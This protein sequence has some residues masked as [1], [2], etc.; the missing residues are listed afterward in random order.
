MSSV[1]EDINIALEGVI[2][3]V[4]GADYNPLLFKWSVEKNDFRNN[5]KMYGSMPLGGS[6]ETGV[7]KSYTIAQTYEFVLTHNY[8][9]RDG[10]EDKQ[11]KTF[12]LFEKSHA[13]LKEV[14]RSKVGLPG[15]VLNIEGI[16]FLDPEFFE[17]D[18]I[19]VQRTRLFI[20]YR[21]TI[22]A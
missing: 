13:I 22:T 16:D 17:P 1:V 12:M 19:V 4:L 8:I 2:A 5:S 7:I 18:N 20:L 3:G 10:D 15:S 6:Q 11:A 21:N 9:N 14:I